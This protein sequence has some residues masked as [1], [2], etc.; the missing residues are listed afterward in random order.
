MRLQGAISG[1]FKK[2]PKT[3]QFLFRRVTFGGHF[4]NDLEYVW[5][6]FRGVC[7]EWVCSKGSFS[8]MLL[9]TPWKCVFRV[10]QFFRLGYKTNSAGSSPHPKR[11]PPLV[12]T[13][14]AQA[15][16]SILGVLQYYSRFISNS[17][18]KASYLFYIPSVKCFPWSPFHKLTLTDLIVFFSRML[19]LN[20][21][22]QMIL[23]LKLRMLPHRHWYSSG[24]KWANCES[25]FKKVN[26]S[27]KGIFSNTKQSV[28][29]LLD[30][31]TL[32]RIPLRDEVYYCH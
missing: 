6:R 21:S 28:S 13:N 26:A 18:Q 30:S 11:L 9:A 17:T 19:F 8:L 16:C 25:H 20:L 24:T 10:D 14:G 4:G 27:S 22:H 32:A 23:L 2:R 5:G 7:A 15:F 31:Q 1:N 12:D 29:H 3:V